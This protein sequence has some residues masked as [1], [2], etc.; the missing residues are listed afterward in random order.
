MNMAMKRYCAHR[1]LIRTTTSADDFKM[2]GRCEAMVGRLKS[3]TRTLL[4]TSAL[5]ADH[6]AFAMRHVVARAQADLLQ[7]LGIK[8]PTLPPFAT[9]VFVKKRS[10]TNRYQEWEEKVIP[11]TVLCPSIDVARGF[12]VKTGENTYLTTTVAVEHVEEVSG[13]FAVPPEHAAEGESPK[14]IPRRRVTGKQRIAALEMEATINEDETMAQKFLGDYAGGE[15]W[16]ALNLG[17]TTDDP[18]AWRQI[19]GKWTLGRIRPTYHQ[20]V[21]FSPNR[22]HGPVT[23]DGYRVALSAFTVARHPH[24]TLQQRQHLTTLGFPLPHGNFNQ[25]RACHEGGDNGCEVGAGAEN[26]V[27]SME[28][29]S[30]K[31]EEAS[32]GCRALLS[33]RGPT[34]TAIGGRPHASSNQGVSELLRCTRKGYEVDPSL[35]VCVG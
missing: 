20:V 10:W 9:K 26:F 8:Q 19:A 31:V 27:T 6:W 23:W 21:N 30:K 2:N 15:L 18:T 16:T 5:G 7:Q 11:A 28:W 17:E 33:Q 14:I 3:A 24:M 34:G 22:P 25:V 4:S 12:L 29:R 35:C 1:G 32:G 13:N